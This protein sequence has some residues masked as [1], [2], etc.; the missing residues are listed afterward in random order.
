M[1]DPDRVAQ[2]IDGMRIFHRHGNLGSPARLKIYLDTVFAGVDLR[3]ARVLDVG[4]GTGLTSFWAVARGAASVEALEPEAAGSSA[5]MTTTFEKIRAQLGTDRVSLTYSAFEQ[6]EAPGGSFDGIVLHNV[7]NHFDEEACANLHLP[8]PA[9]TYR[10]VFR[11][12]RELVGPGGWMVLADA[13]NRNAFGD[14]G[15]RSPLAP[16]VDW[17]I[18]QPPEAWAALAGQCGWRRER[19]SWTP[20]GMF[21]RPGAWLGSNRL[22]AYLTLSHFVLVLRAA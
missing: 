17:R 20:L 13:S 5:G 1:I 18:H 3:G 15:L 14:L 21:G 10:A 16:T 11:R 9:E 2:V 12:C 7:I 22:A 4:A 19:L 8:E 6:F